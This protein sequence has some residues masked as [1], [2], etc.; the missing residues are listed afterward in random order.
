M[1]GLLHGESHQDVNS[2]RNTTEK[3]T[4]SIEGVGYERRRGRKA[5]SVDSSTKLGGD[6]FESSGNGVETVTSEVNDTELENRSIMSGRATSTSSSAGSSVNSGVPFDPEGQ[7][8]SGQGLADALAA[9]H[10]ASYCPD[11]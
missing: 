10:N 8:Y 2:L 7:G 11:K 5:S 1:Q 4:P 9:S 6:E 3:A